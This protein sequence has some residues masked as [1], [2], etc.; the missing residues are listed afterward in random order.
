MMENNNL[1]ATMG[2]ERETESYPLDDAAIEILAELDQQARAL[3]VS[4]NAVLS[5]FARQHK[6]AG[7]WQL[8]ENRRELVRSSEEPIA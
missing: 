8:A 5:Y 1:Q 7:R 2:K 6:L 3:D 4:R